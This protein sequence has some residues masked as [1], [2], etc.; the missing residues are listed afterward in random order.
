MVENDLMV[1]LITM[2]IGLERRRVGLSRVLRDES[3]TKSRKSCRNCDTASAKPRGRVAESLAGSQLEVYPVD[4]IH[5]HLARQYWCT[6]VRR[7]RGERYERLEVLR[8][9]ET[10]AEHRPL[11]VEPRLDPVRSNSPFAPL[12]ARVGH[13]PLPNAD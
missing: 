5:V 12:L 8:S 1:G 9:L 10:L 3:M 4:V 13:A 7:A 2:K 11:L 6:P